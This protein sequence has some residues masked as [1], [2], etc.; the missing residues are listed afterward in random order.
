MSAI[1]EDDLYESDDLVGSSI[2]GNNF[3]SKVS[4]H[5]EVPNMTSMLYEFTNKEQDRVHQSFRTGN[6][7]SIRDLPSV[8]VPGNVSNQQESKIED[9][10]YSIMERRSWVEL[11]NNGGYF[12]KFEWRPDEYGLYRDELSKKR[13]DHEEKQKK[14]HGFAPFLNNPKRQLPLKHQSYFQSL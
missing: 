6:Y 10:L 2:A 5:Y 3:R 14:L 8:I 7:I 13:K 1:K 9:N 4:N 11:S 12:S